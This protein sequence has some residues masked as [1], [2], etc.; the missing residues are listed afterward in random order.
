MSNGRCS[1]LHDLPIIRAKPRS[2]SRTLKDVVLDIPT[3]AT[4]INRKLIVPSSRKPFVAVDEHFVT[5]LLMPGLQKIQVD[6]DWYLNYYPDVRDAIQ[7]GVVPGAK[8]HYCQ[9]GYFE[10][11]MPQQIL[12]DEPWYLSEYPDVREGVVD[13]KDFDSGQDHFERLGYKE[14]RYPYRDFHLATIDA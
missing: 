2:A 13:A 3:Y 6:E 10:H 11:R 1:D 14:G 9:Y 7:R 8:A 12:V 4:L 5:Q